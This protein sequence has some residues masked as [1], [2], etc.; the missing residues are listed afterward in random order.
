MMKHLRYIIR[1]VIPVLVTAFF[2]SCDKKNNRY[3]P[4]VPIDIYINTTLPAYTALNPVGGWVY[5]NG[6]SQGLIIYHD[7]NDEYR[8][9]DRHSPYNVDANCV[10]EVP[11]GTQ[12]AED[13]CSGSQFTLTDGTVIGGPATL[14]LQHYQTVFDGSVIHV[15]N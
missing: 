15:I 5:V 9:Y 6:G 1:C 2:L 14:P 3:I 8:A 7:F 4:Y 11:S 13:P 12:Y 10:V